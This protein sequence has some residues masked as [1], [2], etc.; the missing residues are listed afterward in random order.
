MFPSSSSLCSTLS[1]CFGADGNIAIPGQYMSLLVSWIQGSNGSNGSNDD[2]TSDVSFRMLHRSSRDTY[3]AHTIHG[4]TCSNTTMYTSSPC[5]Y[6]LWLF[7]VMDHQYVFGAFLPC[8]TNTRYM[9]NTRY[10]MTSIMTSPP[11]SH[12]QPFMF[13][14]KN[15]HNI[16]VK[17]HLNDSDIKSPKRKSK[18]LIVSIRDPRFAFVFGCYDLIISDNANTTPCV[19]PLMHSYTLPKHITQSSPSCRPSTFLTG[20]KTFTLDEMEVYEVTI[21]TKTK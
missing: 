14:L 12:H 21:T 8:T 10:D 15:P 9:T 13:S 4:N 5:K 20:K 2:V 16:P 17:L 3:N 7:S 11:H 6:M 19:S 18:P 1:C